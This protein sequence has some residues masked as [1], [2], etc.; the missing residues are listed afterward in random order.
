MASI[1]AHPSA[2]TKITASF[3]SSTDE[4]AAAVEVSVRARGGVFAKY[5]FEKI[6]WDDVKP[7]TGVASSSWGPN[8]TDARLK[9]KSDAVFTLRS[10][11][12]QVSWVC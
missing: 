11:R 8:I 3:T 1:S 5:N 7:A 10:D 12:W 4:V 2:Q 9:T 6:S